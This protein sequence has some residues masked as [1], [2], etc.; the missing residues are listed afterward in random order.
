MSKW[1][2]AAILA[3][4]LVL[5]GTAAIDPVAAA[6]SQAAAQKQQPRQA[7]EWS[8]RRRTWPH[9]RYVY[10]RYEPPVYYERPY[11]YAP[12]P[13]VPFNYGY[14]LWPWW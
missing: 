5:G 6:P 13:F 2:G 7:T 11:Y 8:A 10:R 14:G 1:I 12:A 4:S 9:A 3:L